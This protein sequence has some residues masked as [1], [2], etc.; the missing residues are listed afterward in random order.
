M[1]PSAALLK[2][3]NNS[4]GGRTPLI[5]DGAED[6]L[7][8]TKPGPP[9]RLRIRNGSFSRRPWSARFDPRSRS[10]LIGKQL[11]YTPDM[12]GQAAGHRGS[13][14]LSP[15]GGF[16]QLMMDKTEI[17]GASDQIHPCLKCS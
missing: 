14:S 10:N 16:A 2:C 9:R 8:Q 12:I 1:P 4:I 5:S 7:W 3:S 11:A 17:V 15:V 13:T 6:P